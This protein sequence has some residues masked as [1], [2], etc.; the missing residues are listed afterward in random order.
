MVKN[1][2]LSEVDDNLINGILQIYSTKLYVP[3]VNLFI[4]DNIKFLEKLKQ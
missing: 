2:V 4:N 1:W 3:V